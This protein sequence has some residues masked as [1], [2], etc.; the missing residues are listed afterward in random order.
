ME[1]GAAYDQ[2]VA[3]AQKAVQAFGIDADTIDSL[4]KA[5][6]FGEVIR[7]FNQVGSKIGE[8]TFQSGSNNVNQVMTPGQAQAEIKELIKDVSF[9]NKLLQNDTSAKAKWDLLH[10][11]G[12]PA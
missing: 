3:V 10:K 5:M 12:F 9:Q 1:W 2:N 6:G 7:F 11:W 4:E 8:H